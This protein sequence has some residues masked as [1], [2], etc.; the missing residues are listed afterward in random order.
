M[1]NKS[2]YE[3]EQ[4]TAHSEFIFIYFFFIYFANDCFIEKIFQAETDFDNWLWLRL[5]YMQWIVC[6]EWYAMKH[7]EKMSK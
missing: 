3:I 4:C 6:N 7:A 2:A 1:S 5:I